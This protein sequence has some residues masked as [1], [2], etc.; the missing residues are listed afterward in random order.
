MKGGLPFWIFVALL[1]L[2]H[3]TLHLGL[4]IG[5][6]APDLLTV[7]VL[8]SARQLSGG[9]AAAV[10]FVLGLLEDSVSLG[11]F[12]AAAATQ[13]VMGYLGARSRDLFVGDSALFLAL[14]LFLGAWVQDALY[15]SLAAVVRRGG[16]VHALLIQAPIAAAYAAMAGTVA[17]LL[18]RS[19]RR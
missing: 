5:S 10:G 2:L 8:L 3:F 4:G 1:V 17:V 13:T 18:Y 9:A 19:A 7:A 15:Y 14:Y 16:S 6:A 11:A 12:G